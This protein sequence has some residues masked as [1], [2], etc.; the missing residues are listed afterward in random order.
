MINSTAARATSPIA[1]MT[2]TGCSIL[3]REVFNDECD[4]LGSPQDRLRLL[5]QY[6][7]SRLD[8]PNLGWD[9]VVEAV[10]HYNRPIVILPCNIISLFENVQHSPVAS[11]NV[12]QRRLDSCPISINIWALAFPLGVVS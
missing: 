2:Q 9:I 5:N 7:L 8:Q 12:T 6:S 4:T 11:I 1:T 10:V 3:R